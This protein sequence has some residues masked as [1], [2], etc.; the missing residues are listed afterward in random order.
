MSGIKVVVHKSSTLRQR[1]LRV[2]K[3]KRFITILVVLIVGLTFLFLSQEYHPTIYTNIGGYSLQTVNSKSNQTFQFST[4]KNYNTVVNVSFP[5]RNG[6][7]YFI[8]INASYLK[9]GVVTLLYYPDGSGYQNHSFEF[10]RSNP[11]ATGSNYVINI[12]STNGKSFPVNVSYTIVIPNRGNTNPLVQT[13]G[14]VLL[15]VSVIA[16][17]VYFTVMTSYRK[18]RVL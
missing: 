11:G 9:Y 6:I 4:D 3:D 7:R 14:L 12:I 18:E 1:F 2:W 10:N 16:L 13:A 17:A 5:A 8:M 15:V